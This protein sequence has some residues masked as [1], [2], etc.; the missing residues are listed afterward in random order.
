M[1]A[2]LVEDGCAYLI[3][4]CLADGERAM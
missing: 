3:E 4:G 2:L 1:M